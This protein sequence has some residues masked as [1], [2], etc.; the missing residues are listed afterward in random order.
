MYAYITF[1]I[2]KKLYAALF[3]TGNF[4][5]S[6]LSET[7]CWM[8]HCTFQSINQSSTICFHFWHLLPKSLNNFDVSEARLLFTVLESLS[9][10]IFNRFPFA[11]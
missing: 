4:E 5:F 8:Y 6:L 3:S 11:I 2:P 7:A 9:L 1:I 10:V